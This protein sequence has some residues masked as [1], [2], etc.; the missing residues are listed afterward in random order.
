MNSVQTVPRIDWHLIGSGHRI[1]ANK[2]ILVWH[3]KDNLPVPAV[4][5]YSETDPRGDL[6]TEDAGRKLDWRDYCHW[7]YL[8]TPKA[9]SADKGLWLYARRDGEAWVEVFRGEPHETN[10]AAAVE[11]ALRAVGMEVVE[12]RTGHPPPNRNEVL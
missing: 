4:V 10:A 5:L 8:T 11:T 9:S 12:R 2:R 7:V 1:S 3:K 6:Y